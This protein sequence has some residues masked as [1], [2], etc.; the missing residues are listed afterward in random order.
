MLLCRLYFDYVRYNCVVTL[1]ELEECPGYSVPATR[2]LEPPANIR[3]VIHN[4]IFRTKQIELGV[5]AILR[6][7]EST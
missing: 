1:P 5:A 4:S 3:V 2:L 7:N 6:A